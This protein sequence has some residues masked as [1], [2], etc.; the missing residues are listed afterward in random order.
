MA[1]G[2]SASAIALL[3]ACG[4]G[5]S[6]PSA[7]KDPS[8]LLTQPVDTTN[9]ARR[10]GVLK[11]NGTGEGS[12][13]PNLSVS[14]VS[15][16]HELGNARL[17]TL[18]MGHFEPQ[19]VDIIE[20]DVAESW[21]YSPDRLQIT[22]RL[23][24]NVKFHNLPPVN[25]R[26]L[27]VDDVVF[28]WNRFTTNSPSRGAV[29]NSANPDAPVLSITATDSRT[30]V[31]K[32]KEP[33]AYA[34]TYFVGRELVN[35]MPKE[36][37][38]PSVL[39]LRGTML[40][41]GPFYLAKHEPSVSFVF[42]RHE[43]FWDKNNVFVDQ[44]DYPVI[45]E[46]AQGVAQF[47]AGNVYLYAVRPEDVIQVKRDVP[48][49]S[50]YAG[51]I[52]GSGQ[53]LLFGRRTPAFRD[54]R[55]RQAFSMSYDRE[56]WIDTLE[57]AQRYEAEGLPVERS[58]FGA[59]PGIGHSLDGW[60]P[61]P[62]DARTFGPNAKY[63]EHNVPEAKRLLAAAGFP[64]GMDIIATSPVSGAGSGVTTI[65]ARQSMNS[66]A[67]LRFKNNLV[68]YET[69]F[70][71]K[72]RDSLADFEGIAYKA[73]VTISNDPI[74]RLCQCYWSKGGVQFY[75][76]DAAGRGDASGDPYVDQML[77]KGRI[78]TDTDKRKGIFQS[79]SATW[80]RRRTDCT[81]S[82]APPASAWPGRPSA[83]TWSGRAR[84]AAVPA[85]A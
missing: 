4:G 32:L 84:R 12:L 19:K 83:T 78:E 71:P 76:F 40:G 43:E 11:R 31:M 24:P 63:Y 41:A 53:N 30:V 50:M 27:D 29:A 10:G 74:D 44:I 22:L 58:W 48:Q 60:R 35:M 23:R 81:V 3:A 73:G 65:D 77:V 57:N 1:G 49:L 72:Y 79:C 66:D 82:A 39:D 28:S 34:L 62:R 25:G 45:T 38:N 68:P 67:G 69:E 52:T 46:Y 61:D 70:I 59:F 16:Y 42:K 8:G 6:G 15:A 21:E 55:V 85:P 2:A 36:A 17:V 37:A 80:R 13:D 64:D 54:E 18:K 56:T 7:P 26:V 20:G 5:D 9:R 47:R 14:G 51:D 75:G 33:L